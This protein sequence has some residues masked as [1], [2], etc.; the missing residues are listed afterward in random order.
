MFFL[1]WR[2]GIQK[3]GYDSG[4]VDSSNGESILGIKHLAKPNSIVRTINEGKEKGNEIDEDVAV[5]T[6]VNYDNN[7]VVTQAQIIVRQSAFAPMCKDVVTKQQDI[8]TECKQIENRISI[9]Q[10]HDVIG[11]DREE[12]KLKKKKEEL[13]AYLATIDKK[14]NDILKQKERFDKDLD[15]SNENDENLKDLEWQE[16]DDMIENFDN[17]IY[18]T[19][20]FL[21]LQ[22]ECLQYE[23]D[24]NWSKYSIDNETSDILRLEKEYKILDTRYDELNEQINKN[25]N[26]IKEYI[27]CINKC[28]MER[29]KIMDK[30]WSKRDKYVATVY[31]YYT[32]NQKQIEVDTRINNLAEKIR[33]LKRELE[34]IPIKLM[35]KLENK[36][37]KQV[38]DDTDKY[39]RC[40]T[41]CYYDGAVSKAINERLS[42]KLRSQLAANVELSLSNDE[43]NDITDWL[44]HHG[45]PHSCP[46]GSYH[47]DG[48][49]QALQEFVEEAK[50]LFN[51]VHDRIDNEK[52]EMKT[53][54]DNKEDKLLLL[55]QQSKRIEARLENLGNTVIPGLRKDIELRKSKIEKNFENQTMFSSNIDENNIAINENSEKLAFIVQCKEDV[56]N[57]LH[58]CQQRKLFSQRYQTLC[59]NIEL[60]MKEINQHKLKLDE[61]K[62]KKVENERM[63]NDAR[64]SYNNASKEYKHCKREFQTAMKNCTGNYRHVVKEDFVYEKHCNK[65]FGMSSQ[66]RKTKSDMKDEYERIEKQKQVTMRVETKTEEYRQAFISK[67]DCLD[68]KRVLKARVNTNKIVAQCRIDGNR[69]QINWIKVKLRETKKQLKTLQN[70]EKLKH[71]KFFIK[72]KNDIECDMDIY[73]VDSKHNNFDEK[74]NETEWILKSNFKLNMSEAELKEEK[75]KTVNHLKCINLELRHIDYLKMREKY[76]SRTVSIE[77]L[78]GKQGLKNYSDYYA[79]IFDG[80]TVAFKLMSMYNETNNN[81]DRNMEI[82]EIDRMCKYSKDIYK[83]Q[84]E[85][86]VKLDNLK[87]D[88][89]N[90]KMHHRTNE[91]KVLQRKLFENDLILCGFDCYQSGQSLTN[92]ESLIALLISNIINV[93]NVYYVNFKSF[94]NCNNQVDSIITH[95]IHRI[96]TKYLKNIDNE[97]QQFELSKYV[98]IE[99]L[100]AI[101]TE[102]CDEGFMRD[103][104]YV[105]KNS[106]MQITSN[107]SS[108]HTKYSGNRMMVLEYN[109]VCLGCVAWENAVFDKSDKNINRQLQMSYIVSKLQTSI[110][111][112][113]TLFIKRVASRLDRMDTKEV[114]EK[115]ENLG[116]MFKQEVT[117]LKKIKSLHE[118]N[119]EYCNKYGSQAL[120]CYIDQLCKIEDEIMHLFDQT[121]SVEV[122]Q[123]VSDR[124]DIIKQLYKR[125]I[126]KIV[127]AEQKRRQ[128]KNQ[129]QKEQFAKE[130]SKLNQMLEEL[131][132]FK[133]SLQTDINSLQSRIDDDR[134]EINQMLNKSYECQEKYERETKELA[135]KRKDISQSLDK[136]QLQL[137]ELMKEEKANVSQIHQ[138]KKLIREK[139]QQIKKVEKSLRQYNKQLKVLRKKQLDLKKRQIEIETD[140]SICQQKIDHLQDKKQ[141]KIDFIKQLQAW[142]QFK[143]NLLNA[144]GTLE[145]QKKKIEI[146]ECIENNGIN[147]RALYH[148]LKK[149]V[150]YATLTK[151]LNVLDL[152]AYIESDRNIG[153]EYKYKS[154]K[155]LFDLVKTQLAEMKCEIVTETGK[156]ID[157]EPVFLKKVKINECNV[158]MSELKSKLPSWL[159]KHINKENQS[160][161]F[162]LNGNNVIQAQDCAFD[163]FDQL[164]PQM[165]RKIVLQKIELL[166][167]THELNSIKNTKYS[168]AIRLF[169]QLSISFDELLSYCIDEIQIIGSSSIFLDES[170][171][172][173]SVDLTIISNGEI[174]CGDETK[175][176]QVCISSCGLDGSNYKDGNEQAS[177]GRHKRQ[178]GKICNGNSGFDG[179]FGMSGQNGGNILIKVAGNEIV[180][181]NYLTLES[182]GG[183]GGRAQYGGNGDDGFYGNN[184]GDGSAPDT[185]GLGAGQTTF[186]FGYNGT[187]SGDGG[188]AGRTGLPG[189]GGTYGNIV[190]AINSNTYTYSNHTNSHGNGAGN[191]INDETGIRVIQ[192]TGKNGATLDISHSSTHAPKGGD[193]GLPTN[194]GCDQVKDKVSFWRKTK[195]RKGYF[196]PK[197]IAFKRYPGGTL[198]KDATGHIITTGALVL[199]GSLLG[200]GAVGGVIASFGQLQRID[201]ET[202]LTEQQFRQN[203]RKTQN[204]RGH[205]RASQENMYRDES[206][207]TDISKAKKQRQTTDV[208]SDS[209]NQIMQEA[210]K[211]QSKILGMELDDKTIEKLKVEQNEI[212]QD[213]ATET[214][215]KQNLNDEM[216]SVQTKICNVSHQMDQLFVKIDGANVDTIMMTQMETDNIDET[217]NQIMESQNIRDEKSDI[218]LEIKKEWI[219]LKQYNK[220]QPKLSK[221]LRNI[222]SQLSK[223]INGKKAIMNDKN[224]KLNQLNNDLTHINNK[225]A[226][227]KSKLRKLRSQNHASKLEKDFDISMQI[228]T[229]Q[230]IETQMEEEISIMLDKKD[231]VNNIPS[232]SEVMLANIEKHLRPVVYQTVFVEPDTLHSYK[233]IVEEIEQ[234]LKYGKS[235]E[236]KLDFEFEQRLTKCVR[237]Y[238]W[239]NVDN[240]ANIQH[241]L[242]LLCEHGSKKKI[243]E[244][245]QRHMY[246][247]SIKKSLN[248]NV[249]T[250]LLH[251]LKNNIRLMLHHLQND[252]VE[253]FNKQFTPENQLLN[254]LIAQ[255]H[256]IN[257]NYLRDDYGVIYKINIDLNKIIDDPF[258]H[259]TI[260][261]M[262][263]TLMP[264]LYH[265][266]SII[267]SIKQFE[268]ETCSMDIHHD[269]NE[270]LTNFEKQLLY[271]NNEPSLT[272]LILL[273][274]MFCKYMDKFNRDK[275]DSTLAIPIAEKQI[276][277]FFNIVVRNFDHFLLEQLPRKDALNQLH[278]ITMSLRQSKTFQNVYNKNDNSNDSSKNDQN[279]SIE[280]LEDRI[281]C[282]KKL[283][284]AENMVSNWLKHHRID[285]ASSSQVTLIL[286]NILSKLWEMSID[287]NNHHKSDNLTLVLNSIEAST[288]E[289]KNVNEMIL[290]LKGILVKINNKSDVK[291][292]NGFNKM[293]TSIN[294]DT[295]VEVN[296]FIQSLIAHTNK[297]DS[298][299]SSFIKTKL[300]EIMGQSVNYHNESNRKQLEK[301]IGAIMIE[302][303]SQQKTKQDDMKRLCMILIEL[304][305]PRYY[306]N[307][308]SFSITGFK[309]IFDYS[310]LVFDLRRN[311]NCK[312]IQQLRSKVG[313]YLSNLGSIIEQST[314]IAEDRRLYIDYFDVN[315]REQL[316]IAQIQAKLMTTL[317]LATLQ[318]I[319]ENASSASSKVNSTP[320]TRNIVATIVDNEIDSKQ[321]DIL[322]NEISNKIRGLAKLERLKKSD[323]NVI[324]LDI[325]VSLI[326]KELRCKRNMKNMNDIETNLQKV[327]RMS[328]SDNEIVDILDKCLQIVNDQ[329]IVLSS[330]V[331][332]TIFN[333]LD[334]SPNNNDHICAMITDIINES[335][336]TSTCKDTF[337]VSC[338]LLNTIFTVDNIERGV[339]D[340]QETL[341]RYRVSMHDKQLAIYLGLNVQSANVNTKQKLLKGLADRFN[342]ILSQDSKLHAC[343]RQPREIEIESIKL[344]E[345]MK[346]F[347]INNAKHIDVENCKQLESIMEKGLQKQRRTTNNNFM[348]H[349]S[350][351]LQVQQILNTFY[352][353]K[354][355]ETFDEQ[356]QLEEKYDTQINECKT[357]I[358]QHFDSYMTTNKELKNKYSKINYRNLIQLYLDKMD[359]ILVGNH[360]KI[361]TR[362]T[363]FY[364]LLKKTIKNSNSTDGIM[365]TIGREMNMIVFKYMKQTLAFNALLTLTFDNTMNGSKIPQL[366][367]SNIVSSTR[368]TVIDICKCFDEKGYFIKEKQFELQ[369][370]HVVMSLHNVTRWFDFGWKNYDELNDQLIN[371]NSLYTF[372]RCND[373]YNKINEFCKCQTIDNV[374]AI[375]NDF[376]WF[377]Q[378]DY[379]SIKYIVESHD[380]IQ[381]FS[382]F[383]DALNSIFENLCATNKSDQNVLYQCCSNIEVFNGTFRSL[384][385]NLDDK[386]FVTYSNYIVPKIERLRQLLN[387]KVYKL[388]SYSLTE[389]ERHEFERLLKIRNPLLV[390]KETVLSDCQDI[391]DYS[392][393]IAMYDNDY[394]VRSQIVQYL[395]SKSINNIHLL[396]NNLTRLK[397]SIFDLGNIDKYLQ[398]HNWIKIDV[399]LK[400]HQDKLKDK[401]TFIL[402][403]LQ[404]LGK[405]NSKDSQYEYNKLIFY[406]RDLYFDCIFKDHLINEMKEHSM[407][408]QSRSRTHILQELVIVK[409]TLGTIMFILSKIMNNNNNMNDLLMEI[410]SLYK[411]IVD[412]SQLDNDIDDHSGILSRKIDSFIDEKCNH[413]IFIKILD[414]RN[415]EIKCSWL[416]L[417]SQLS[418]SYLR[419]NHQR[420]QEFVRHFATQCGDYSKS[421][422]HS[423]LQQQH[424]YHLRQIVVRYCQIFYKLDPNE[425]ETLQRIS[426]SL[427]TEQLS[428]LIK[429][430]LKFDDHKQEENVDND[431][432]KIKQWYLE[433]ECKCAREDLTFKSINEAKILVSNLEKVWIDDIL[434][435]SRNVRNMKSINSMNNNPNSRNNIWCII[436][437]ENSH[438]TTKLS[439]M[440]TAENTE[441]MRSIDSNINGEDKILSILNHDPIAMWQ[442]SLIELRLDMLKQ[443]FYD[444]VSHRDDNHNQ[445]N[446]SEFDNYWQQSHQF[447]TQMK[448]LREWTFVIDNLLKRCTSLKLTLS[449]VGKIMFYFDDFERLCDVDNIICNSNNIVIE[450]LFARV[451]FTLKLVLTNYNTFFNA[452]ALKQHL[453]KLKNIL[454]QHHNNGNY[455]LQIEN[456]LIILGN[457]IINCKKLI[458]GTD[459]NSHNVQMFNSELMDEIIQ[460]SIDTNVYLN[461]YI[462][463]RLSDIRLPKWSHVLKIDK[464]SCNLCKKNHA[465]FGNMSKFGLEKIAHCLHCIGKYKG[466]T[467]K[468]GVINLLTSLQPDVTFDENTIETVLT[469]I[470]RSNY[471]ISSE[472][473]NKIEMEQA[474]INRWIEIIQ[475]CNQHTSNIRSLDEL[476]LEMKSGNKIDKNGINSS[477]THL[478]SDSDNTIKSYF[479]GIYKCYGGDFHCNSSK[480]RKTNG[481]HSIK[482]YSK[483][484]I[485]QWSKTFKENHHKDVNC[486]GFGNA[487]LHET[488][489]VICQAVKLQFGYFPR[490]I[491]LINVALFLNIDKKKYP[492]GRMANISTGEGK[493]LITS[494]YAILQALIGNTVDIVTSS[495]VLAIRDSSDD[496]DGYKSFYSLFDIKVSNNCDHDC[497]NPTKGEKTRIKRYRNNTVIYGETSYFQRDILLTKFFNKKLR[498][499]FIS[500]V[501]IID[502]CDNM[503]IDNCEKILYISHNIADLRYIKDVFIHIWAAV[504]SQTEGMYSPKNVNKIYDYIQEMLLNT[505]DDTLNVPQNLLLFVNNNLKK[506]IINAYSAKYIGLNDDYIIGDRDS[507]KQGNILIMDKDTGVEQMTSHWSHGLHQFLQLKHSGKLTP[508]S[509]KA[510]FMSNLHFFKMYH[511]KVGLTGTI[512]GVDERNLL[513][514]EYNIDFFEAPHFKQNQFVYDCQAERVC[515]N[516]NQWYNEIIR[517]IKEKMDSKKQITENE[518]I[519]IRQQLK[520][521][522]NEEKINNEILRNQTTKFNEKQKE[523]KNIR[524][525]K[526]SLEIL[527]KC[528]ISIL[529]DKNSENFEK[530]IRQNMRD[531]KNHI[532]RTTQKDDK[533]VL[534]TALKRYDLLLNKLNNCSDEK[535]KLSQTS[536]DELITCVKDARSEGK[537]Y[538]Q[539]EL[540][541]IKQVNDLEKKVNQLNDKCIFLKNQICECNAMITNPDKRDKRRAV[542]IICQNIIDLEKIMDKIKCQFTIENDCH[543]DHIRYSEKNN[544]NIRLDRY[545]RAYR[546]FDR[547][548]VSPG[549]VIVATNI[550]GRGTDLKTTDT[551]KRNGGL[552]VIVSYIPANERIEK[553][554]FGRTARKGEP[555]SGTYIVYDK[556]RQYNKSLININFLLDQRNQTEK[557]RLLTLKEKSLHKIKL[558]D[559]LFAQFNAFKNQIEKQLATIYNYSCY[560]M[561]LKLKYMDL[562]IKSLQNHWA[563][564]LNSMNEKFEN[565]DK[566]GAVEIEN[567]FEQF[568]KSINN[569]MSNDQFK[570]VN[571]P[572]EL[573]KLGRL[574]CDFGMYSIAIDCF[575]IVI[576]S[577]E[578]F[579]GQSLYYKTFCIIQRDG[580][581]F[582]SKQRVLP[583]LK[584]S[585]F[586]LKRDRCNIISRNQIIESINGLRVKHGIGLNVN[587]FK[588]QN[589]N[590]SQLLSC[591]INAIEAAI[592][593][594][595]YE[596][597]FKNLSTDHITD[598]N[599]KKV[600]QQ[601]SSKQYHII[602]DYRLSK[603]TVIAS[604]MMVD[605]F[606]YK[607][608]IDNRNVCR[609]LGNKRKHDLICFGDFKDC[610]NDMSHSRYAKIIDKLQNHNIISQKNIYHKGMSNSG[611]KLQLIQFSSNFYYCKAQVLSWF[612]QML[613]NPKSDRTIKHDSFKKY[614]IGK[615]EFLQLTNGVVKTRKVIK[616][617][618]TVNNTLVG[619]LDET[620]CFG[621]DKEIKQI[622]LGKVAIKSYSDDCISVNRLIQESIKA[623]SISDSIT[624]SDRQQMISQMKDCLI[625]FSDTNIELTS[626]GLSQQHKTIL[627]QLNKILDNDRIFCKQGN[628]ISQRMQDILTCK[629]SMCMTPGECKIENN[630]I[631]AIIDITGLNKNQVCKILDYIENSEM[632]HISHALMHKLAKV[633]NKD[634]DGDTSKIFCGKKTKI[635]NFLQGKTNYI[636]KNGKKVGINSFQDDEISKHDIAAV[637]KEKFQFDDNNEA[638]NDLMD[639]LGF[640][641]SPLKLIQ[642][643]D[644]YYIN[645]AI[646]DKMDK[647]L[648]TIELNVNRFDF[649]TEQLKRIDFSQIT[650]LSEKSSMIKRIVI[651]CIESD[652]KSHAEYKILTK[653]NFEMSNDEFELLRATF[654]DNKI[655]ESSILNLITN[656][657][658]QYNSFVEKILKQI[659]YNNGKCSQK[660]LLLQSNNEASKQLWHILN[661]N[662]VIKD[663][664]IAFKM[665]QDPNKRIVTI[666]TS[667]SQFVSDNKSLLK[668]SKMKNQSVDTKK[669]DLILIDKFLQ[670]IKKS[671]GTLRIFKKVQIEEELL[672]DSLIKNNGKKTHVPIELNDFFAIS[673]EKVLNFEEYK[674]FDWRITL[675]ALIGIAQIVAGVALEVLTAGAAHYVAQILISEG[676]SDMTFAITCAIDNNFTWEAY[677]RH[678]TV[679]LMLSIVSGGVGRLIGT[680]GK[681]A[682]AA[683]VGIEVATATAIFKCMAKQVIS[684]VIE[685]VIGAAVNY[686]CDKLT[687]CLMDD[688]IDKEFNKF[689]KKWLSQDNKYLLNKIKIQHKMQLLLLKFGDLDGVTMIDNCI[690]AVVNDLKYGNLGNQIFDKMM[691]FMSTIGNSIAN[692]GGKTCKNIG[693]LIGKLVK[694]AHLCKEFI[695]ICNICNDF[696]TLLISKLTQCYQQKKTKKQETN[697]NVNGDKNNV[698]AEKLQFIE[699][700][701]YIN[702]KDKVK[703]SFV[704]PAMQK[705]VNV[706]T[707]P[708]RM[709]MLSPFE[710]AMQD[711]KKHIDKRSDQ[712]MK[713][714]ESMGL[715]SVESYQHLSKFTSKKIRGLQ[716]L[717]KLIN[718]SEIN[719]PQILLSKV[720]NFGNQTLQD[721][722]NMH[723][724]N[725]NISFKNGEIYAMIPTFKQF[726]KNI[727]NNS[728]IGSGLMHLKLLSQKFS[729]HI[730]IVCRNNPSKRYENAPNNGLIEPFFKQIID[731]SKPPFKIAFVEKSKDIINGIGHFAP[732]IKDIYGGDIVV[733]LPQLNHSDKNQCLA[734]SFVFLQ[735]YYDQLK[736]QNGNLQK[737]NIKQIADKAIHKTDYR[738]FSQKLSKFGKKNYKTFK[739]FYQNGSTLEYS[740]LIGGVKQNLQHVNQKYAIIEKIYD[741]TYNCSENTFTREEDKILKEYANSKGDKKWL[742]KLSC[743]S[744]LNQKEKEQVFDKLSKLLIRDKAEKTQGAWAA[745]GNDKSFQTSKYLEWKNM[746]EVCGT[747]QFGGSRFDIMDCHKHMRTTTEGIYLLDKNGEKIIASHPGAVRDPN[748]NPRYAGTQNDWFHEERTKLIHNLKNKHYSPKTMAVSVALWE[749]ERTGGIRCCDKFEF[750]N[751]QPLQLYSTGKKRLADANQRKQVMEK[752]QCDRDAKK[753][754]IEKLIAGYSTTNKNDIHAN[755]K[756]RY[757]TMIHPDNSPI[758]SRSTEAP[759]QLRNYF[760]QKSI[761]INNA[762]TFPDLCRESIQDPTP[763]EW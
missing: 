678:K 515:S 593:S 749:L 458:S 662:R 397:H 589:E 48:I 479:S 730:E 165:L 267:N 565:L 5:E 129:A 740:S 352:Q 650:P 176:N 600:F 73:D 370:K 119:N 124:F 246:E 175:K 134:N 342:D 734:Q 451:D 281:E 638:L 103:I 517:E 276:A 252:N 736:L 415:D 195:P 298:E 272:Q 51:N 318:S 236:F 86:T 503:L 110:D 501:L 24:I 90:I 423:E 614:V 42:K 436:S 403:L 552:H 151:D 422:L 193:G 242:Q 681:T 37:V 492:K 664:N 184:G 41:N 493:S 697:I 315:L 188:Y 726:L 666:E 321:I 686:V 699:K 653:D 251:H 646:M 683:Y 46:P 402:Q 693:K 439:Q 747:S 592:G 599:Y 457:S 434:E 208:N 306:D 550:A 494:M 106:V 508:E 224:N 160:V 299:F 727:D 218:Q 168:D 314:G 456:F 360:V 173:P 181:S 313:C 163:T 384:K 706:I 527:E 460:L 170:C 607:K 101:N 169:N 241:I 271:F 644:E 238:K 12:S 750:P 364:S 260:E 534:T 83:E 404:R 274:E 122:T 293:K 654:E 166:Y 674:S 438:V 655:I 466:G 138:T 432:N 245:F 519:G 185:C 1:F 536:E 405:C 514:S 762:N 375:M 137:N 498:P 53:M 420:Y 372:Y 688:I 4:I 474:S 624:V 524:K 87:Q 207:R 563:F 499:K 518:K 602:K 409:Q 201:Y 754:F 670:T 191:S 230:E 695:N 269:Q 709:K 227:I 99:I 75:E 204:S 78:N 36:I 220:L 123:D 610:C 64:C 580:G 39:P 182:N 737:I 522:Q 217:L 739:N 376:G 349:K 371:L 153:N 265:L 68:K 116:E 330:D 248:N 625:D 583:L 437:G 724:D 135:K 756:N 247:I 319:F 598:N 471:I 161:H 414:E 322:I 516:V 270:K 307:K 444:C 211:E 158:V 669:V 612:E 130:E 630:F 262:N 140:K 427:N 290:Q 255:I 449:K 745:S 91:L 94:P 616:I 450:L 9:L 98:I 391:L 225:I 512:G 407:Q 19:N 569:M 715:E 719:N 635:M 712:L 626:Q 261:N 95:G 379:D 114:I 582:V 209:I 291:R 658:Q 277:N 229:E 15:T 707:K 584:K 702:V 623:V 459:D 336:L 97:K 345:H 668:L 231:V 8:V 200:M 378:L 284:Q 648:S 232:S 692:Q 16:I 560:R 3:C 636:L 627:N 84:L 316:Q 729:Q 132:I 287:Y 615:E 239:I 343:Q 509:L 411:N 663:K 597:N 576:N 708:I 26:S 88:L 268:L 559:K 305:H 215:K 667:L 721:I 311:T 33:G 547:N 222:E 675:I 70:Y 475:H 85:L 258:Y 586:L 689:F 60:V 609:M 49:K 69:K 302:F 585:L 505:N 421:Q 704:K 253:S 556:R 386:K 31:E 410:L 159:I 401:S 219:A 136:L 601:L 180:D 613:N 728:I 659:Y 324:H 74:D 196:L 478:L 435:F 147:L 632:I 335:K 469:T 79:P 618:D 199:G 511:L 186:G 190:I 679:S 233:L 117:M 294:D 150:P 228:E 710:N 570:L 28:T 542:L 558:E 696:C 178:N 212:E 216:S 487:T 691:D 387:Y 206:E 587:Y 350:L 289:M 156:N 535:N 538:Q 21:E 189:T 645:R 533:K 7:D 328:G 394:S 320:T 528:G 292:M 367:E 226:A 426:N 45:F 29:A 486:F 177:H 690:G 694:T 93:E 203:P 537:K 348:V 67:Q 157:N 717:S 591:H 144:L 452:S 682:K 738:K 553:Q 347:L 312:D 205:S 377:L 303:S 38:Q 596:N 472:I 50:R 490:I 109:N 604:Q 642:T 396:Q 733:D 131:G 72:Q 428:Q 751:K 731:F 266:I 214:T 748:K 671:A 17:T 652:N 464:I 488:M 744:T 573:T 27:K 288:K 672:N 317:D 477:I 275:S 461:E 701:M 454:L 221:H 525:V 481:T 566:I 431:I 661:S 297:M 107:Y 441:S 143:S 467:V 332:D 418:D 746:R 529:F 301:D 463:D 35:K 263:Q 112:F 66:A 732:V 120:V 329:Y 603:K 89:A 353:N 442:D 574:F 606:D 30:K 725:V 752:V 278:D 149:F 554:A 104:V 510:V 118:F 174:K 125:G 172:F 257:N 338:E 546:K 643:Y 424:V 210:M 128:T 20:H 365:E 447:A 259:I 605:C 551:L 341:S 611:T 392:K 617:S 416:T 13:D 382:T 339:Q 760:Q 594:N 146:L 373:L 720:S 703:N 164:Q 202:K 572:T 356:L 685:S 637:F 381:E 142:K 71:N 139:Q 121:V 500:D 40:P 96:K 676:I 714:M 408:P 521:A 326:G 495:K 133:N 588:Q 429:T 722:I 383:L 187:K 531:L 296:H 513:Q 758:W 485:L 162:Y 660:T 548:T 10:K 105:C 649:I 462:Q 419:N 506:W 363:F 279:K 374:I 385:C 155:R 723:G 92:I 154:G 331:I 59:S 171:T 243:I 108:Q 395:Q 621:K 711:M 54:I 344:K 741:N 480:Y 544:C 489:A 213:I 657:Q 57:L 430:D 148:N 620:K 433:F 389:K 100:D 337:N 325:I 761:R 55:Q 757:Q 250:L 327:I 361:D 595:V 300:Y 32:N 482:N 640:D 628:L 705:S 687:D 167:P 473:L 440:S 496:H 44:G 465:V 468:D 52:K 283:I 571:E 555:G 716:K 6:K 425:W 362:C 539:R 126:Y 309:H 56:K 491:Q 346:H 14:L 507:T 545:D 567:D 634:D 179:G 273:I 280:L 453:I 63:K 541:T 359:N 735:H 351:I 58:V 358:L 334:Y 398:H 198:K 713:K 497:D 520:D 673:F 564:W 718:A 390:S 25:V 698:I 502:E 413:D 619:K 647:Y 641:S 759:T 34:K 577:F 249:D 540:M 282:A 639:F 448:R 406:L 581:D 80:G 753:L 523:L 304:T 568:T 445:M 355:I 579:S 677:A 578:P 197:N 549:D 446:D 743:T 443:S 237:C 340:F 357:K 295:T 651:D 368:E 393:S 65:Y 264:N 2:C 111:L 755:L 590:I 476:L 308:I 561:D 700:E 354:I 631:R 366:I 152:E 47:V 388:N 115:C 141:E 235:Q 18:D 61:M 22:I 256:E 254:Q 543:H 102:Y 234:I 223:K 62:Q 310:L 380:Y 665:I 530:Q 127:K 323:C 504:N 633:T 532:E 43:A 483:E 369:S 244:T 183:N 680:A 11:I 76:E 194:A 400:Y 23:C 629:I 113:E 417:L 77:L 763:I 484:D 455:R 742:A 412:N 608:I 684:K 562:Q 82:L 399:I 333:N 285:T 557:E 656:C 526:N 145:I 575:D 286:S 192:H 81:L 240:V 622:L 470:N